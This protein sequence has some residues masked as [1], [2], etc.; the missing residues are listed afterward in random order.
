MSLYHRS[1]VLSVQAPPAQQQRHDVLN[2]I[3]AA[4]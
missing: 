4:N 1:L 3:L 2:R